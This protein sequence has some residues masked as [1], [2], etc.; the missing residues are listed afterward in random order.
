MAKRINILNAGA[1]VPFA[2]G[3]LKLSK[4]IKISEIEKH[5]DFQSL[6][7]IDDEL[8]ERITSSIN[9]N[10]FDA[11]QPVHI[12]K[13]TDADGTVH[14]YLIDGYTRIA[15][16]EKA[17][18]E[19]V[20]YF[21]HK[22]ESF[23]EAYKYVLSLQVNRRN[24]EGSELLKNVSKLLGTDFIQNVEGKKSKAIADILNL[25]DRTVEKAISVINN[26]DEE[27]L[28]KIDADELTVNKAYNQDKEKSKV[29]SE[30]K[31]S[32]DKENSD[33]SEENFSDSIDDETNISDALEDNEGNPRS[34][35]VRS[36]DMSEHYETPKESEMDLRLIERYKEGFVNGFKK[37]ASELSY[38]VY[39]K[40]CTLIE[41]GKSLEEIQADNI[42]ADFSFE[43]FASKI[44]IPTES[45]EILKKY[46]K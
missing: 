35:T 6:F 25:S 37:A 44:S 5:P 15:A 38:E 23:E 12:W 4:S 8:L 19:T 10:G 2:D 41:E 20:P 21:E 36:R 14:N 9:E 26:A 43:V 42:F 18:H 32:R 22:F 45:E 39:E 46:N 30:N 34:V 24:L 13:V 29:K 28:A 7:K 40:I 16:L 3:G 27:T 11:S 33:F 17:G 1:T 31:N